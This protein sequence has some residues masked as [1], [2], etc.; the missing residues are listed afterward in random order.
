MV[1]D[2]VR[3]AIVLNEWVVLLKEKLGWAAAFRDAALHPEHY[4]NLFMPDDYDK[5]LRSNAFIS[6]QERFALLPL[7]YLAGIRVKC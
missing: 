1:I 3:Q 5:A 6:L 2:S 4:P 7:E